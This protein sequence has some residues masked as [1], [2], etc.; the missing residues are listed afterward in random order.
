MALCLFLNVYNIRLKYT[1]LII[2]LA[3]KQRKYVS[4]KLEYKRDFRVPNED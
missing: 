2:E 3:I 1:E 4:P